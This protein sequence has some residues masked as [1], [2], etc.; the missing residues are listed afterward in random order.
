MKGIAKP[1]LNIWKELM[2]TTSSTKRNATFLE[3]VLHTLEAQVGIQSIL[4]DFHHDA[5]IE[6]DQVSI[7]RA[8]VDKFLEAYTWLALVQ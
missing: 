5:F 3:K 6:V 7:L 2:T 1:L 8:H 4:D